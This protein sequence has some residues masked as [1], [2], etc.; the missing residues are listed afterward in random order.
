[1]LCGYGLGVLLL[2]GFLFESFLVGALFFDVWVLGSFVLFSLGFKE[3]VT[4][5]E[6]LAKPYKTCGAMVGC[7]FWWGLGWIG[8]F[9]CKEN[10]AVTCVPITHLCQ[11][12]YML[13]SRVFTFLVNHLPGIGVFFKRYLSLWCQRLPLIVTDGLYKNSLNCVEDTFALFL[14]LMAKMRIQVIIRKVMWC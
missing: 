12:Y 10:K 5:W 1:M 11:V 9:R 7:G 3:N 13:L 6:A 2:W 8:F 14:S 4:I